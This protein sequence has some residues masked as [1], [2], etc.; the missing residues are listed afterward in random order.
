MSRARDNADL[1]DSYGSLAVG[2]TGGSGL[3]ALSASNLSAG[4]VPDARMPNL[5]GDITTVEGAVATTIATDAVDI[6]M[7]SATGTADGTTF[8]RGDNAWA[9]AGGG[10]LVQVQEDSY[11]PNV[12]IAVSTFTV[13]HADFGVEITPASGNH[14]LLMVTL[15]LTA[16]ADWAWHDIQRAITGGATTI[17]ISGSSY[18]ITTQ[19]GHDSANQGTSYMFLDKTVGTGALI[20]YSPVSRDDSGN[21]ITLNGTQTHY[22]NIIAIEIAA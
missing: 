4:T 14:V 7:L 12:S 5:T 8:L 22:S 13:F 3:N 18:G 6:A 1:G 17:N 16:S 9:T 19:A 20:K 15:G 2:V 10:K 11:T 21:N